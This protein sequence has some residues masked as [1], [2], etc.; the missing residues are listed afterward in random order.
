[1]NLKL[2]RIITG[3]VAALAAVSALA[4]S[5]KDNEKSQNH[6]NDKH[7]PVPVPE[8]ATLLLLASG[9]AIACGFEGLSGLR[10]AARA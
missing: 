7:E 5:P 10:F 6:K 4:F 9:A 8:P 1:M 2:N 3:L